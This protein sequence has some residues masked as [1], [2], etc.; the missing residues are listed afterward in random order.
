M[1]RRNQKTFTTTNHL[2]RFACEEMRGE[3]CTPT[4]FMGDFSH[5]V[6]KLESVKEMIGEE[7]WTDVGEKVDW[8]E[9]ETARQRVT[10]MPGQKKQEL[11]A[12]SSI[13]GCL[14]K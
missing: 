2:I 13:D 9:N 12:L 14:P 8:W 11:M 3:E 10:R 1:R 4:A 6:N 5:T 7:G